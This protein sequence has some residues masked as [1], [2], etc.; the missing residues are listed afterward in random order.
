MKYTNL[1][2][3]WLHNQM[4]SHDR[5]PYFN[6][7]RNTTKLNPR[8]GFT[9]LCDWRI[10]QMKALQF[11]NRWSPEFRWA[12]MRGGT[13]V[14]EDPDKLSECINFNTTNA[15]FNA[16]C[17]DKERSMVVERLND[18]AI[19]SRQENDDYEVTSYWDG[20][21]QKRVPE[22]KGKI[23][24]AADQNAVDVDHAHFYDSPYYKN[25]EDACDAYWFSR[26]GKLQGNPI[27]DPH[28]NLSLIHI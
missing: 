10:N 3:P 18:L 8:A 25:S 11:A 28:K 19:Y 12:G 22:E 23:E 15:T 24:I 9:G 6:T 4:T 13:V 20:T 17:T 26:I 16:N 27:Y 1:Y 7:I 21:L 5:V 14:D 2:K